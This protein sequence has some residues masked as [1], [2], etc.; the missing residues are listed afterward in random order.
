MKKTMLGLMIIDAGYT[1]R[2][3]KTLSL[4]LSALYFF[5]T[6]KG[7]TYKDIPGTDYALGPEIYGQFIWVPVSDISL[8]L[9]AGAFL[10]G[11]G[12]SDSDGDPQWQLS[13]SAMVSF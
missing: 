11:L 6:D 12:A 10:P 13:L 8:I 7:A 2:L 1:A 4:D 5:R 3:L 9:G